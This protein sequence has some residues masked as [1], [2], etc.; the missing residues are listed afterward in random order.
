[1][2]GRLF[3]GERFRANG[4]DIPNIAPYRAIRTTNRM[5]SLLP[6]IVFAWTLLQLL[7]LWGLCVQLRRWYLPVVRF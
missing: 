2:H 6:P 7:Y 3:L 4:P 1:M 5:R